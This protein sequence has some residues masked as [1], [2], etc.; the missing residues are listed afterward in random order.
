MILIKVIAV[1]VAL[2]CSGESLTLKGLDENESIGIEATDV[3]ILASIE[4][5][6]EILQTETPE[7]LPDSQPL[8]YLEEKTISAE[9]LSTDLTEPIEIKDGSLFRLMMTIKQNWTDD[10]MDKKS[11]PFIN[12]A[13]GLGG[14]LI[15]LIDNSQEAKDPNITSF[16]LVEVRPSKES[17]EKVYVTFIVSA[18]KEISGEEMSIAIKNRVA[19]Y[20]SI[21]SYE[22]TIEGFNLANITEEEA[23]DM[24]SEKI[25]CSSGT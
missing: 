2:A 18:K 1:V 5:E 16:K 15:D 9:N 6:T 4:T 19:I 25:A 23:T 3:P 17:K 11:E 22:A 14:E 7:V 20:G 8:E 21:Y 10:F 12:L 24:E 13:V